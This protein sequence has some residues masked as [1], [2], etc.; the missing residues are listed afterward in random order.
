MLFQK[1]VLEPY[2]GRRTR[3][4]C[5]KCQSHNVFVRY[6]SP[7]LGGYIADHVGRCNREINCGY[8]YTPKQYYKDNPDSRQKI[9]YQEQQPKPH[10]P[11]GPHS[12]IDFSVFK[13]SLN[14]YNS[15]RLTIYLNSLFGPKITSQLIERYF[16]GTSK[17]WSGA[18]VFWQIDNIG[19][20]R[21]GKIIL[22]N[23]FNGKRCKDESK[24]PMWVHKMLKLPG[25]NL[26]QCFFGE[27]LLQK[28]SS[29]P[30]GIV[31][32]EKTAI[33]ASV[34]LPQFTWLATGGKGGLN[35]EKCLA[36]YG[37]K[38]V[39]F[40]DLNA[41]DSWS[42]KAVELKGIADFKV[43]ELLERKATKVE[44]SEGLDLADYLIRFN[45]LTFAD[46]A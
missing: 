42:K 13:G 27:H 40:P 1:P 24:H 45:Y 28:E 23:P 20:L 22:Y 39:L 21:T 10:M 25:F 5:P 36:L 14:G 32:S 46:S 6:I 41:F 34:Y 8:H 31:E 16:I 33:I 4:A 37:R 30:I 38:V 12:T 17:L 26:K 7:Y 3:H 43:S 35:A 29:K 15:N 11:A 9:R 18:T 44:R 2:R 19:R